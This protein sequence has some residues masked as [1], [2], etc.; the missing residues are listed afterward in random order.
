M[1]YDPVMPLPS[2]N[3][4]R[5]LVAK[6]AAEIAK[7]NPNLSKKATPSFDDGEYI[8]FSAAVARLVQDIMSTV[9]RG[10]RARLLADVVQVQHATHFI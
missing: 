8:S 3:E 9:P 5:K 7:G 4:L 1:P 2:E 10:A 6:Y